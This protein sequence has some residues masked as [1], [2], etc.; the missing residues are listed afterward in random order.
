MTITHI[1]HRL[2]RHSLHRT[3]APLG[4]AALILGLAG[5]A[6]GMPPDQPHTLWGTLRLDGA[7]AADGTALRALIGGVPYA[8]T[9][10]F[11]TGGEHGLYTLAVP[12]DNTETAPKDGGEGGDTVT[13]G[14]TDYHVTQTT[15]WVLGAVQHLDLAAVPSAPQQITDLAASRTAGPRLTL[16]WT[17]V[18]LDVYGQEMSTVSYRVYRATDAPYFT[19]GAVYAGDV[20]G[21]SY[22]DPDP[23]VL[24]S[25]GHGYY[26]V[27]RAVSGLDVVSADS[28]R[29]GA[30][31]FALVPGLP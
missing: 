27:V 17:P 24:T 19:P 14:V 5:A 2:L 22:T 15:T 4:V 31:S 18:T 28:D 20:P 1:L 23:N 8:N 13:F 6:M 11:S 9:A 30:F 29:V 26:Y 25:P 21:P 16:N 7:L 12:G 10:A 3:L